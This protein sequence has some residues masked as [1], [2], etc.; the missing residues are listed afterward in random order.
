MDHFQYGRKYE[1]S[2]PHTLNEK[3][4]TPFAQLLAGMRYYLGGRTG[5]LTIGASL[6]GAYVFTRPGLAAPD[7]HLHFLPFM[8]G[9]KGW[10]LAKFSGFRLGMYQNRPLSR[11][12][13]R[14]TSP[15]PR[16]NPSVLFNH[17]ADP[18]DVRTA[19]AGMK[20]ARRIAEA[21]P[22]RRHIVREIEPGPLGDTDEGLL[23]Y[24]RSTGDTGFHFSGTARMG[25]DDLA[26]VD[27]ELRVR[28]V[29]RL[30]VIDASV[31]PTIVSGN[32]NAAVLMIGEK[33]ADLVR[34]GHAAAGAQSDAALWATAAA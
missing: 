17:L 11:G 4:G 14:I 18:E 9:E 2:S 16:A 34:A 22:L 26:V 33:G 28:G 19:I 15:D 1:T 31:M 13:V 25:T 20:L 30:R 29:N 7:L 5:P 21:E 12:R 27:P 6:A 8:P 3:V 10:D 24:I 23:E 32:I